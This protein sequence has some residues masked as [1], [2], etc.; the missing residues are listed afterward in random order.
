MKNCKTI[1]A[2]IVFMTGILSGCSSQ[3]A[4]SSKDLSPS[5]TENS[6]TSQIEKKY[7][8]YR[9]QFFAF[10][11]NFNPSPG[12]KLIS[13]N[14]HIAAGT[15]SFP[16]SVTIDDKKSDGLTTEVP[17]KYDLLY[18][19]EKSNMIVQVN[20]IY[21]D[22]AEFKEDSEF[23]TINTISQ[24]RNENIAKEYQDLE[25]PMIDEYFLRYKNKLIVINFI[26]QVDYK[27]EGQ[28]KK[29]SESYVEEQLKFYESFEKALKVNFK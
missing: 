13:P 21:L 11:E 5:A 19:S 23:I 29:K 6:T 22:G 25:R 20:F 9:D 16:D 8:E 27:S 24:A 1:L 15:V 28:Y 26:E 7:I 4:K 12:F 17:T 2:A 3:E 10:K 18:K 14:D